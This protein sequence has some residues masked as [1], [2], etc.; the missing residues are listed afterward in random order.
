[1]TIS[2]R[3]MGPG[4][5]PAVVEID[6][7]SF[8]LPW[9]ESS[10]RYEIHDNKASRCLVAEDEEN[11]VV[12]MI[13][14]WMIL[15][16]LHIATFATQRASTEGTGNSSQVGPDQARGRGAPSLPWVREQQRT[17]AMYEG[18]DSR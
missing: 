5:I 15:D 7:A 4:D 18:S 9:P 1:M 12:A 16:E 17:Q 10:Y 6:R 14:S 11:G 13:V 2:V 8:S 3:R